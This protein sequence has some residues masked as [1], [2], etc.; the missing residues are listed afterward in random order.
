MD[1]QTD[2]T[3]DMDNDSLPDIE[4]IYWQYFCFMDSVFKKDDSIQT[5][6]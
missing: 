5:L 3:H 6:L 2:F 4:V 1:L